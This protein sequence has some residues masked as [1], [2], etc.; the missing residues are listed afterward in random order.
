MNYSL[1]AVLLAAMTPIVAVS[2]AAIVAY[3][4]SSIYNISTVFSLE[5][6]GVEVPAVYNNDYYHSHFEMGSGTAE[7]TIVAQEPITKV[8]ISPKKH[9]LVSITISGN[10][11]TFTL[12][13]PEYLIIR[14]NDLKRY[15]LLADPPQVRV[16]TTS[17]LGMFTIGSK[18]YPA[19]PTGLAKSTLAFESAII[20]ASKAWPALKANKHYSW[21]H[22]VVVVPPGIYVVGN[23]ELQS[24]VALYLSPGA[25]L[26]F[27]GDPADYY[28]HWYKASIGR[29]ITWWISTAFES[30]NIRVFGRGT[31]DGNGWDALRPRNGMANNILVPISTTGFRCEGVT[32]RNSASW[33]VTPINV[34]DAIFQNIKMLNRMDMGEN[35]GIDVMHSSNVLVV[36]AIGIS[37]D[38]PFSTKTWALG[39]G[40]ATSWPAG[41]DN[42]QSNIT[43]D[44]C[45]S[46]SYC[47][48]FKVGQGVMKTQSDITFMNS[49]VYDSSIGVGIN[50]KYGMAIV[51]NIL[52]QNIDIERTNGVL[53][54]R[55][56]WELLLTEAGDTA[57]PGGGVTQGVT[58]RDIKVWTA[59][60]TSA[61]MTGLR[62]GSGYDDVEFENV[63]MP[64][65]TTAATS[66]A[67]LLITK[68]SWITNI[69]IQGVDI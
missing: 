48:G 69:K 14:V 30:T 54:G 5:V 16:P 25:V 3:P 55:S 2:Q 44:D 67:E 22:A 68:T 6:N 10:R 57:K 38:D 36:R 21:D 24:N 28:T 34:D 12:P 42:A 33:S 39:T 9:N 29:N 62:K 26:R 58:F 65:N 52:F 63:V 7:V 18:I 53:D 56:S 8:Y 51:S 15:V 11:A 27:T 4:V 46:W 41:S 31:F 17:G 35:D 40:I 13:Q 61:E 32:F 20:D 19:D 43:F 66:L 60:K 50:H 49:V 59:G 64:G 1:S 23:V 45:L 47:Y 37:L